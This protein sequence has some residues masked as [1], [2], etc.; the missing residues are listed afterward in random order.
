ML[1]P[2]SVSWTLDS[3]FDIS[4]TMQLSTG[5]G[6]AFPVSGEGQMHV[7]VSASEG[8]GSFMSEFQLELTQ[9]DL[10][11]PAAADPVDPVFLCESSALRWTGVTTTVDTC[12][13][14][15]SPIANFAVSIFDVLANNSIDAGGHADIVN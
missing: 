3:F 10:F 8:L 12:P 6:P 4:Y 15:A 7:V 2:I 14:C 1:D 13:P 9:L 5:L 11:P